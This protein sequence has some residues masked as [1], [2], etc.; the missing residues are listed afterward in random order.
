MGG[1][2]KGATRKPA[3][4]TR[5]RSLRAYLTTKPNIESEILF[6]FPLAL[7]YHA[8]THIT[9]KRSG[10]DLVSA[11]L[12]WL[13]LEV[14]W[15][16]LLV[17]GL[18]LAGFAALYLVTH[19]KQGF[20]LRMLG[21]VLM[22]SGIYAFSMGTIIVLLLIYLFR[23]KPPSLAAEGAATWF[24]VFFISAGA[25]VHEELI[26]RLLIYG[27]TL[28]LLDHHTR[29]SHITAV[30]VAGCLSSVLFSLAH[31]VP[32]HGEPIALW[33]VAFR[34]LAGAVFATIYHM[35]GLSVTV[36]THFLY[37]VYVIGLVS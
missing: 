20:K 18:I 5:R 14:E 33:P 3:E 21:T 31:H 2:K 30:A 24:D 8:G 34:T 15:A 35:R 4:K 37:D 26:F 36:Y 1:S 27:G 32:P 19:R 28:Y 7:F 12:S 22:E 16:S 23:L 29:A 11:L 10:V 9:N 6:I 25:G 13:Y 17:N